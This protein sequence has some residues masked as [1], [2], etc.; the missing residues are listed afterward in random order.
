MKLKNYGKKAFATP[1]DSSHLFSGG[2]FAVSL[3]SMGAALAFK[4]L[5]RRHP[6]FIIGEWVVPFLIMGI[7]DKK[8]K[9]R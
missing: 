7:Y 8:R 4:Q 2:Y 5:K 3:L 9:S 6:A 1:K